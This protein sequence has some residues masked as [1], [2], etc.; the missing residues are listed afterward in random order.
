MNQQITSSYNLISS[1]LDSLIEEYKNESSIL[2]S[3]NSIENAQQLLSQI[4]SIQ[5]IQKLLR[6]Q[7]QKYISIIGETPKPIKIEKPKSIQP[8]PRRVKGSNLIVSFPDGVT[9]QEKKAVDTF[10][11][12]IETLGIERVKLL[13][14]YSRTSSSGKYRLIS[15][16]FNKA[17]EPRRIGN[18]FVNTKSGTVEKAALLRDISSKLNLNLNI[19]VKPKP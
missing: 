11:E 6:D 17:I 15:E 5:E 1:E 3:N 9:I 12:T 4:S 14:F 16:D 13:N 19:E 10:L 7:Q 2:I 18:Y 8:K